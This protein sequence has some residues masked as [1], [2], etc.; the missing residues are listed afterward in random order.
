MSRR[1]VV[2]RNTPTGR[3]VIYRRSGV[4]L[5][6]PNGK[7]WRRTAEVVPVYEIMGS[8]HTQAE[9]VKAIVR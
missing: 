6:W 1:Y 3:W 4:R 8:S 7:P 2:R 9:A 5:H